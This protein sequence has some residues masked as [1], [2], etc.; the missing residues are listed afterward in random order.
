MVYFRYQIVPAPGQREAL[1]ETN[2]SFRKIIES[3]GGKSV[4][5]FRVAIGQG[6]GNLIY[7]IAYEDMAAATAAGE[8]LERH[9]EYQ[10]LRKK[11]EPMTASV[12]STLLQPLPDSGLQ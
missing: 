5:S 6:D 10:A 3:A 9:P 1:I 11:T 7:L 2:A 8:A 12:S 4:A